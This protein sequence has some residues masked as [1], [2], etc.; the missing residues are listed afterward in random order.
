MP[1]AMPQ[2]MP[3]QMD[4]R[5]VDP[6][7][8]DPHQMDPLQGAAQLLNANAPDGEQLAFINPQEAQ[9]LRD[10]GG[11]GV[12][13]AGGVPSYKGSVEAP[14]PRNYGQ[15]TRDTLQAQVDLSPAL[16]QAERNARP[17]YTG[18]D[19]QDMN[20]M[21]TGERSERGLL[22]LYENEL[23]PSLSRLEASDRDAR[24]SGEMG[25]MNRYAGDVSRT[26]REATG[27]A[28]LLD[29][30]NAQALSEL[31]AGASLDP[32]LRREIQQSVRSGQAAR[33]MG[34]G[35]RDLADEATV[36][37]LQSEQ[38]RR[39]RQGFAQ[40]MVGLN[41]ATGGDPFMAIL[42][43]PSQVFSA[44]QNVGNNAYGMS[45][46][47]GPKLFNPESQY[48]ADINNQNWQGQLAA[49][50]A[51]ASNK[52]AL[53]GAMIGG[54]A[55]LG[56]AA[57]GLCW[58]ARE[59]YGEENP[60]WLQFREWM[61]TKAPKWFLELYIAQGEAFAKKLRGQD[62]LKARIRAWMDTKIGN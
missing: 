53:T 37:A 58:V 7:Q 22:D 23:Q 8:M 25:A 9:I 15:E 43:R 2:A 59:V 45:Q 28:P 1:Q 11:L 21:L 14:P 51:S 30:L 5:Q 47:M 62:K 42:G 38:L 36:T 52:T 27:N 6:R 46:S 56:G 10:A 61:T 17:G 50:T 19:L 55:T 34:Y 60:K 31:Q 4:P 54:A 44:T 48:S 33:G 49:R 13:A 29:E 3:Q 18:L 39:G 20:Q 40:S 57:I 26:L 24:I 32:S 41:Q 12:P 16:L 35:T